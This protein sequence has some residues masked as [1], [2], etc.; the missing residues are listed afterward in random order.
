[1]FEKP[2][3]PIGTLARQDKKKMAS[4]V[5]RWNVKMRS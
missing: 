3:T 4:R 1:M 2:G 5:T